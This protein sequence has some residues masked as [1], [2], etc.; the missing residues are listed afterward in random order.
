M[1][2]PV[3]PEKPAAKNAV[4]GQ[5]VWRIAAAARAV[6][7]HHAIPPMP[8]NFGLFF[9]HCCGDNAELS[10]RLGG[11][12]QRGEPLTDAVLDMLHREFVA[13]EEELAVNTGSEAI[14]QAAQTLVE[15][16]AGGQAGIR[17]YG[18]LLAHW[19][20]RLA[21]QPTIGDLA[22]AI[23]T[24]T[25]ETIRA[26]ERNRALEQQLSTSASRI[27]RLRLSLADVKH[28]A[29]TDALTGITNRKGFD[30]RLS[31]AITQARAEGRELAVLLLDIDHFKDFNDQYG[32]RTGDMVLRLVGRVLSDNVKGR[33]CAARYGGE[34]FAVLLAGADLEAGATVG[35]QICAALSGK[36]LVNKSSGESLGRITVSIGVARF[37]G[38]E[39]PAALVERADRALYQAKRT[40]RNRVCLETPEDCSFALIE[41]APRARRSA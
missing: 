39:T 21:D 20:V 19:A 2:G 32:H 38:D 25:D 41:P 3:K 31:R 27:N 14:Q 30:A 16:V 22:R 9:H 34:E 40:G 8:R 29:T 4:A 37:R 35:R 18:E 23:S 10:G 15:Q 1:S 13:A 36:Q 12:L 5:D 7:E 11:L 28:K 17:A 6:M 26:G 33:D 24:L